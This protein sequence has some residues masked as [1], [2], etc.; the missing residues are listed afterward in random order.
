[1]IQY[2]RIATDGTNIA[3]VIDFDPVGRYHP[4]IVWHP[5]TSLPEK[6][7]VLK[8]LATARRWLHETGGIALPVGVRVGTT[9]ED[10]NRI[11]SVITNAALAGA[12]S[13]DFKAASG[14]VTLS[15]EEVRGIA[16]AIAA[17][18]QACFSAERAH[19]AAIDA[20]DLLGTQTYD[21]SIGWPV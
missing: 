10:Q 1:M 8:N 19:H 12:E 16:A 21:V 2:V 4:I 5:Y 9:I 7:A 14:W 20:L 18:V 17:H 13:V 11:T 6:Q 15:L 3:E